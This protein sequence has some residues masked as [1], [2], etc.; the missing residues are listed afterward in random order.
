MSETLIVTLI[1]S[2][3]LLAAIVLGLVLAAIIQND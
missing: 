2:L 3:S 1:F